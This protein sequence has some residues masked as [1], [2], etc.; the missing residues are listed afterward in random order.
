M[1][2]DLDGETIIGIPEVAKYTPG[3][4]KPSR[5][6]I[7]R[8]MLDGLRVTNKDDR[9]QLESV[10]LNGIRCTSV[11][12]IGRFLRA[13]NGQSVV[14]SITPRQRRRQAEAANQSLAA[15]GW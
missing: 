14:P 10:K 8:W 11:E 4:R 15:K 2:I 7:F 12:A 6:T 9:V 3:P 13:A 1:A 5:A